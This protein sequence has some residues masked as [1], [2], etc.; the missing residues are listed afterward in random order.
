[1]SYYFDPLPTNCVGDFVCPA[2]TGCGYPTY[3]ISKGAEYGYNNLAVFYQACSFN[4]LYCQNYHFKA[5]TFASGRV[6]ASEL[7]GKAD[8]RTN[9][10]CYFGGDPGPQILHAIKTSKIALKNTDTGILRVCW[11]TNGAMQ[12]PYLKIMADL[13]FQSGGCIKFD[14]KSWDERIHYSLCGVSNDRTLENFRS[15]AGRLQKRAKPPALI[16]STLLVPGYVDEEEVAGISA[17]IAELDPEIPYSL[18]AF[19]PQF[20]LNDLPTTS[21]DQAIRCK[22]A[23]ERKGLRRVHIGNVHLL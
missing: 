20:Y 23:A 7:A 22:V 17:F 3:S 10:I 1:L 4:C 11:E 15:I 8:H 9:C 2:G 13:S 19:Y 5:Q 14:L 12:L 6:S 16:A 21:R 18:L